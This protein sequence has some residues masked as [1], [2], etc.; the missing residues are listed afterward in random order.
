[1]LTTNDMVLIPAAIVPIGSPEQHLDAICGEQHYPRQWFEDETPQRRIT[2]NGFRI[3][4]HPVTNLDFAAFVDATGYVT[5]AERRG[6]GLVYGREYWMAESG[7]C[8]RRPHL[9]LDAVADRPDHPVVHVDQA[10][11]A[12]YAAWAG[13]RLPTEAEWEYAAHGPDWQAWPWG[14]T[15]SARNANTVEYWAGE[16][17]R[18]LAAWKRWWGPRWREYGPLPGTTP[19][20]EFPTGCSPFGV[21][22]MAG[23]VIEWT[24]TRYRSYAPGG[25]QPRGFEAAVGFG[26]HVVRG[27]SWKTMR[28][29]TRTS[30]RL[31]CPADYST[32]DIGFRCVADLTN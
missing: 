14:S 11:A 8:W 13:K 1:M 25:G 30:E 32:F 9:D 15:W 29:Q 6:D 4:R 19:V 18:D 10:D 7:L 24:S 17:V 23:N 21:A 2:L 22:D 16:P 28:W 5:A 27:G 31:C 12:A 3:D 26:Y 20:G